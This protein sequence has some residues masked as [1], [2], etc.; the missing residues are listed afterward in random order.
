V[1]SP[2]AWNDRN[3]ARYSRWDGSQRLADFQAD[4]ILDALSDDLMAEGD[5]A[6]ALERLFQRGLR[7]RESAGGGE[8]AGLRDLLARLAQRRRDLLERYQ[9]GDVMGDIRREL[10]EVVD[11]ERRGIERRLA[12]A[13]RDG[14]GTEELRRMLGETA[15]RRQA[16]LDALPDDPGGRVRELQDYDFLEPAA[17][18]QFE[19]LLE[20]L[21]KQMLDTYFQGLSDQIK[22]MTPEQLTANREMVRDLNRLLQERLEGGEPDASEFLARHGQFFPGARTLDDIIE[23]LAARM[24][25]MQSL[26]A[27]MSPDQRAEL[28]SMMD[29]LLRDDRLRWDLAQ[30]AATLDQ[31][32]PGGL[33]ERL[34][35]RGDEEL[36]LEGALQQMARLQQM[37]R[38]ADE[39]ANADEPAALADV[40]VQ[41]VRELL[42]AE[43]A[44]D[45]EALQALARR[46]EEAGYAER[47]GDRLEL[48]PRGSRRIGQKVLE[49]LFARLSRDAFGGH[50]IRRGGTGGERADDPRAYEFGRPFDLHLQRTLAN[51]LVR[52]ENNPAVR[53][54][55]RLRLEPA[56]FEVY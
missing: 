38:L 11:T 48:T 45:L 24:A 28:Q 1:T 53:G 18:E 39:L 19:A 25:A 35:F 31:L 15:A 54:A 55:A 14:E 37:D 7:R 6:E 22:G 8:I 34:T 2:A 51:A 21:R 9:L 3:R 52:E 40:N 44:Q 42:D 27:S 56:D 16:A 13:G 36:S 20:K 4:E 47:Q 23:Q 32:L 41:E 26:L 10:N 17:R 46:L 50:T 30:M 33:G 5:L 29:A 49:E 43:S 12:D